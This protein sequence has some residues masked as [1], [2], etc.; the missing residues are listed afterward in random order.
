MLTKKGIQD[1]QLQVLSYGINQFVL[2]SV[3]LRYQVYYVFG[4]HDLYRLGLGWV[5]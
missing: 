4:L 2:A 5:V 3:A 1:V